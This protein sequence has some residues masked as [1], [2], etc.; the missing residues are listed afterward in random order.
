MADITPIEEQVENF[1]KAPLS[2]DLLIDTADINFDIL[3]N[4][5]CNSDEAVTI[6]F[7]ST[8]AKDLLTSEEIG[9]G[10]LEQSFTDRNL[11]KLTK[12]NSKIDG[13]DLHFDSTI[14][15]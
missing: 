3:S 5:T 11:I 14:S 4:I 15:K 8:F 7:R 12:A 2:E 13:I 1:L 6:H 10:V 9:V